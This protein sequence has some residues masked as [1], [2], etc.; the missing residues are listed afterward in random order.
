MLLP[1]K[2]YDAI[3]CLSPNIAISNGHVTHKWIKNV[4]E[5]LTGK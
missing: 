3:N 1:T 2:Y 5:S 4:Y